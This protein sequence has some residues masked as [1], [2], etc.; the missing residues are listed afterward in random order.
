MPNEFIEKISVT[1]QEIGYITQLDPVMPGVQGLIY[2]HSPGAFRLGF[3]KVED[4]FLFLDWENAVF[5]RQYLLLKTY[6]SFRKFVNQKFAVPHSLRMC[7]PNLAVIAVSQTEFP[8]ETIQY[9][10]TNFLIPWY[11]G[12]TGQI[13]LLD[14]GRG[15][16]FY[17]R[18][19]KTRQTGSLPLGHTL[20]LLLPVCQQ[21][22]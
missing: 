13:I 5:S 1:L 4:H 20:D 10:Q 19:P 16:M 6:Q 17:H 18:S 11:G 9:A 14:I 15:T 22:L 21:C 12:E 8:V 2:A 7:I 3:A